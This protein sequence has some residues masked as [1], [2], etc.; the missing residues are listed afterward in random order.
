M[1]QFLDMSSFHS[2]LPDAHLPSAFLGSVTEPWFPQDPV[3]TFIPAAP[4]G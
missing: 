3:T 2:A 4:Q 1:L